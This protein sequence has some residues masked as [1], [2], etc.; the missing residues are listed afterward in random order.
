MTWSNSSSSERNTPYIAVQTTFELEYVTSAVSLLHGDGIV[1]HVVNDSGGAENA[2]IVVYQN[3]GA[4]AFPVGTIVVV[5]TWTWGFAFTVSES[6]EYWVRIQATSESLIPKASFERPQN[7]VG[8]PMV[9]YRPGDFAIFMLQP[10]R[11][12]LL[13]SAER[14]VGTIADLTALAGWRG[15]VPYSARLPRP[16]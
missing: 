14:C 13:P 7:P 3:T 9:S 15:S 16:G 2:H 1:V 12:R 4:G 11:K 8:I 5:P 10:H 6:G